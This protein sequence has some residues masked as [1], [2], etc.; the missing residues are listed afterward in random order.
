MR[1]SG[2]PLLLLLPIHNCAWRSRGFL[3]IPTHKGEE[4]LPSQHK[5]SLLVLF[6]QDTG[7]TSN[8][9]QFDHAIIWF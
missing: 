8:I 2:S 7:L 5:H 1:G 3:L 6:R 4:G 9:I